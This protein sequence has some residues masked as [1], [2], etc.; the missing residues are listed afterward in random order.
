MGLKDELQMVWKEVIVVY[1]P[2]SDDE[3]G[4]EQL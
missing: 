1:S 3:G 2:Y 4:N